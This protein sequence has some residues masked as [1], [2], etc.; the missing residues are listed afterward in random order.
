MESC[1]E[2]SELY[3]YPLKG[4]RAHALNKSIMLSTGFPDDRRWLI[5]DTQSRFISQRSHPTLA[6]L[7]LETGENLRLTLGAQSFS[8]PLSG[9]SGGQRRV[10]IWNDEVLVQDLGNEVADFLSGL[11]GSELRLCSS[12]AS[13]TRQ[14][15]EK[16]AESQTID[17]YFADG[18]PYLVVSQESLDLLN[19][20]LR[21]KQESPLPM[22]RFRPNIVIRGWQAH[23]E[24]AVQTL[25][26]GDEIR[27]RLIKPCTR[28]NVTLVN[29][30]NGHVGIE[31][32]QTLSTYRKLGGSK[33]CFGMN[34]YLQ[35]GAG[36]SIHLGDPVR[37]M[38][39]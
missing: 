29:Q 14:V 2:I 24:D 31:P 18:F 3:T 33:I 8:L 27:L 1:M 30:E 6:R 22:N 20:K 28:C 7:Q 32:L 9:L 36:K 15:N 5:V 39:E 25:L 19:E 11:L 10:K 4:A 12:I 16:Y 21:C 23:A 26:I 13:E 37:I 38:T 34:A 35:A 17:Y